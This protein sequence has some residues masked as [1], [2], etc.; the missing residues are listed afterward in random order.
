MHNPT[1]KPAVTFHIYGGNSNK[2]GT[3]VA[4]VYS[5]HARGGCYNG[6]NPLIDTT[7]FL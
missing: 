3:N 5:H 1:S 4:N 2:I 6:A 7:Q